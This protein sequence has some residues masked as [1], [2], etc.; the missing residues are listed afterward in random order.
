MYEE[1]K[2]KFA[3]SEKK[4]MDPELLKNAQ[5]MVK[6]SQEHAT[7]KKTVDLILELE[8]VNKAIEQNNE[9]INSENDEELKNMATEELDT[10]HNKAIKLKAEIEEEISPSSPNDKKNAIIEIRAGT[11][12]DEAALFAGDLFRMYSR[13][14][15]RQ[16]WKL[17]LI[18]SSVIGIGGYKEV[19]FSVKGESA[20]G[21]LKFEA[22]THRVQRVPETEKQGRVH[23]ST[24]TVVVLPEAEEIDIEIKPN[25][26]RI[27]TFCS[28]GPGGQCVNTTYSAIRIVHLPTGITVSCQDQ[29][30]Q[31]QNK[32]KAL[33]VLRSRLL[34]KEEEDRLAADS[35]A[36]KTQIGDGDRSDKIRTYN[37]PQDRVTDHRI[38]MSWHSIPRIMDGEIEE[39]IMALKKADRESRQK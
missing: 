33:Q 6:I 4:L 11:G 26:I 10:L 38:N 31:H 18:D 12:G 21:L 32:E 19:V 16:N 37:F 25:D 1:I 7:L 8:K 27:D 30:S 28:S 20:F 39:L 36:R 29:K 17:S 3:D 24:A 2:Q 34:A 15:E 13:F 5:T 9:I 22:G 14:C 23:T 35:D